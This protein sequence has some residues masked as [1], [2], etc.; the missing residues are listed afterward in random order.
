MDFSKLN[1]FKFLAQFFFLRYLV[2][3]ERDIFSSAVAIWDD[4]FAYNFKFSFFLPIFPPYQFGQIWSTNNLTCSLPVKCRV[5]SKRDAGSTCSRGSCDRVHPLHSRLGPVGSQ[6]GS[7]V[8][9]WTKVT[10]SEGNGM[11]GN[12]SK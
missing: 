6:L 7:D 1:N 8:D 12:R 2:F 4:Q 5:P 10:S 11:M 9:I 3:S